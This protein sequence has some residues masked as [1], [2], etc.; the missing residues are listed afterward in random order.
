MKLDDLQMPKTATVMAN[1]LKKHHGIQIPVDKITGAQA[2]VMLENVQKKLNQFRNTH[3]S[4]VA[5][6][7][8]N[9]LALLMVEQTL[10]TVI[11]EDQEQETPGSVIKKA[12]MSALKNAGSKIRRSIPGQ[13]Y[14]THH[15][16]AADVMDRFKTAREKDR[17]NQVVSGTRSVDAL[18]AMANASDVDPRTIQNIVKSANRNPKSINPQ[19]AELLLKIVTKTLQQKQ[20]SESVDL[21]E[22]SVGEAEVVLAAKDMV[23]RVQD[24]VETLGKMVNEELPALSETIRDT[25]TPEQ[26]DA[27]VTSATDAINAALENIRETKNLLDSATQSLAG[28]EPLETEPTDVGVEPAPELDADAGTEEAPAEAEPVEMPK[29][30]PMG[31]AKR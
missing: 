2:G 3:E 16:S 20:L 31:R 14:G 15:L 18:H 5:E 9:Y 4:H 10:K 11:K 26:A 29:P 7:N 6:K 28:E 30:E 23:D 13:S 22:S 21:M 27:F 17:G 24:M 25:M 12:A 8:S 19:D 1:L